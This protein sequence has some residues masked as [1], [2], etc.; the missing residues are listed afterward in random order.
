MIT[1]EMALVARSNASL[2]ACKM[3]APRSH[4]CYVTNQCNI[5]TH[6]NIILTVLCMAAFIVGLCF[7]AV[8]TFSLLTMGLIVIPWKR[9]GEEGERGSE[10]VRE[11]VRGGGGGGGLKTATDSNG[12]RM[13]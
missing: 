2:C 11:G 5:C 4:F 6:I 7:S 1:I 10:G 8:R 9:R 12:K 3:L 13:N